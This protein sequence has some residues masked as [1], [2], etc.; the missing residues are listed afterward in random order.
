MGHKGEQAVLATLK[1][2][3]YWPNMWNDVKH[4]VRSCHQ[5]QIHSVKKAQMPPIPSAPSTIFLRIYL[6]IMF[7]PVAFGYRYIVAARD[8]LSGAA[9]G[10][11][12]KF[13]TAENLAKFFWEEILCRY[14]AVGQV[15]TDNGKEVEGAFTILMNLYHLPRVQISAYNSQANG[16]VERGHFNIRQSILKTCDGDTLKWPKYVKHAFFA[17]KVTVRRQTGFSPFYLLHGVHPVLPLDL[18]EASF[19]VEGFK[20]NMSTVDLLALRIRQLE[21]RPED[22]AKAAKTLRDNRFKS[23]EQFERRFHTRM[24]RDTYAPGSLVL[25]RNTRVEDSMDRKDKPRY[26]GP[27]EVVRQTRNGAYILKELDGT[28]WRQAIAGFRVIPYVTRS[29]KYLEKI[30]AR[31]HERTINDS[32]DSEDSDAWM[33]SESDNEDDPEFHLENDSYSDDDAD[34]DFEDHESDSSG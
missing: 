13:A 8:D 29:D 16:V 21:K 20:S 32:D 30:M 23:K 14:G 33:Y 10:R 19:L 31:M 24:I 7:M 1:E 18:L 6:D 3:F 34:S 17:D 22:L 15:T 28:P 27:Y 5:C 11:A 4:H 26:L 9:E 2:R 25:V 12:L